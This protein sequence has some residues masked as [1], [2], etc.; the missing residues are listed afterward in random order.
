[1]RRVSAF[2]S[3]VRRIDGIAIA[4]VLLLLYIAF[5]ITA[6]RVFTGYRIYMSFFESVPPVLVCA[7]GLTFVITAGEIDLSFPAIVAFS[8][9]V[10]AWVFKNFDSP[11]APWIGAI[12]ASL[13]AGWLYR[14]S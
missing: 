12:L 14:D 5:L 6:P 11:L 7:L 9:F 1:M 3:V 2:F 13:V 8:G 4:G 10:F